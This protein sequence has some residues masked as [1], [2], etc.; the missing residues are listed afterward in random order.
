MCFATVYIYAH[1]AIDVFAGLISGVI[2]YVVLR[3]R[4]KKNGTPLSS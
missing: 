4:A 1:Y 2:I 3:F